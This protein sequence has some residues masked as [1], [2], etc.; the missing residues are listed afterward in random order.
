MI[1]NANVPGIY[2]TENLVNGHCYIGQTKNL[3]NRKQSH[4]SSLRKNKHGNGHLQNAYNKYG[5]ESFVFESLLICE[6]LELTKYEQFF[7]DFLR[8]EYNIRK[9]C[10]DGNLGI[11]KSEE[12]KKILSEKNK[13]ELN[14]FYGKRHSEET[15][16]KI[17]QSM[18]GNIPGNKGKHYSDETRKQMSESHLWK[19]HSEETKRKMSKNHDDRSGE[20]NHMY[21][22]HQ[23]L[24]S[25]RKISESNKKR[26]KSS[27]PSSNHV[28]V[29]WDKRQKK[30]FARMSCA[31]KRLFL[32]NFETEQDAID[33]YDK[34]W[35]EIYGDIKDDPKF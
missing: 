10:V 27:E 18:T 14:A 16:E 23:G 22:K 5:E 7:V 31:G 28:G 26:N 4:F 9:K 34:K 30:W 15:R 20:N 29:S 25:R 17:S 3:K 1:E 11:S 19:T 32:G 2:K 35:I 8:P 24:E 12:A 21:G 6:V 13:G 33:A